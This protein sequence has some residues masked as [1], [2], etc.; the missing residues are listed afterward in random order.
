MALVVPACV[1][2]SSSHEKSHVTLRP[3]LCCA[4]YSALVL[5][6]NRMIMCESTRSV[7]SSFVTSVI[8]V[9]LLSFC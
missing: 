8:P 1:G 4:S 3:M 2:V 5:P 9:V 6:F 7:G